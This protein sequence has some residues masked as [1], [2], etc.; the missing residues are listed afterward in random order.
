MIIDWNLWLT[1]VVAILS[2]DLIKIAFKIL[3]ESKPKN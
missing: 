2:V 3:I 1:L